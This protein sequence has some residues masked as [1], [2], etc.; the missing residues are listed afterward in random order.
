MKPPLIVVMG[1]TGSGKS[2]VG[3]GLAEALDVRFVDADAL[4]PPANVDKMASGTPLDDD[5]RMP[6]LAIVGEHLAEAAAAGEGLVM[7]CSALRRRYRDLIRSHAPETVFVHLAGSRDVLESRMRGRAGHFMPV[8]LLDSQLDTLEPLD[9]DEAG[10][11]VS[12]V[13]PLEEVV[14]AAVEGVAS[15]R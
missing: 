7:A 6:W 9:P 14:A 3:A 11:T 8:G 15:V 4:H 5:D 13:P 10:E 12:I 1:V 2:A